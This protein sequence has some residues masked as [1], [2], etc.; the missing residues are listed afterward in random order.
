V[1]VVDAAMWAVAAAR[2]SEA[3]PSLGTYSVSRPAALEDD[4]DD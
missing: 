2:L 4:D 1:F 3:L